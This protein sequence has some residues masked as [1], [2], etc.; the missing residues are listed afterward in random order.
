MQSPVRTLINSWKMSVTCTLAL[1][2]VSS[3]S[4][5]L[6]YAPLPEIAAVC[7]MRVTP[8]ETGHHQYTRMPLVALVDSAEESQFP[9][10]WA[11]HLDCGLACGWHHHSNDPPGGH[12][13]IDPFALVLT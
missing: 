7:N 1:T 11:I 4:Q 5:E 10:V 3:T 8:R 9:I 13:G 2:G 6:R 12:S